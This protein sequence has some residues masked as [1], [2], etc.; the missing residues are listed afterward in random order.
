MQSLVETHYE[1]VWRSLRRLGIQEADAEDV[2][3]EVFLTASRRLDDILPGKERAFLYRTA[4][5]HAAHA[6]RSR[7][8]RR[9]TTEL[10]AEERPSQAPSPEDLA[11]RSRARTLFYQL[12]EELSAEQRAVFSLYEL[13]QMTMA[14][15]S[16]TLDI[17]IGTVASRLRRARATF[18]KGLDRRRQQEEAR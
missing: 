15:I 7:G 4:M 9:E 17:P 12:M 3:Q 18:A 6:R 2:V 1:F 16:D 10:D 13:D 5:N 14:E 8:R 11:D